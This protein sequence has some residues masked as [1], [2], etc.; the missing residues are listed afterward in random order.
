MLIS[1]TRQL[2]YQKIDFMIHLDNTTRLWPC[3]CLVLAWFAQCLYKNLIIAFSR[4]CKTVV[5]EQDDDT[6][7]T[8]C[9]RVHSSCQSCYR[10]IFVPNWKLTNSKAKATNSIA[11]RTNSFANKTNS[12]ANGTN[13][14][15]KRTNS[16][17][18]TCNTEVSELQ[19]YKI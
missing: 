16:I 6:A 15:A 3:G 14:I 12:F 13:S 18:K 4:V 8:S 1:K 5:L 11:N 7:V 2:I 19:I 17:A 10:R 9:F